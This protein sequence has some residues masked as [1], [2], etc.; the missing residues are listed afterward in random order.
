MA[1]FLHRAPA[2]LV[3]PGPEP[4][5][6]APNMGSDDYLDLFSRPGVWP[7]AAAEVDVFKFYT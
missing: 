2:K 7:E 5:W 1:A 3:D 6:F 4:V